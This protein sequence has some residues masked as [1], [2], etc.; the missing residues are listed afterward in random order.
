[1][2]LFYRLLL[3]HYL[4][5]VQDSERSLT[6]SARPRVLLLLYPEEPSSHRR[7]NYNIIILM[8]Q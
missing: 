1:M 5:A 3:H 7:F 2:H 6:V 4:E 8:L